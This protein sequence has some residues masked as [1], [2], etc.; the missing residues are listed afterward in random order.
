M[1]L[2]NVGDIL[3]RHGL[4]VLMIDFDLEAPGLE[5]YFQVDQRKIRA[6]LGLFDLILHYKAAMA[7]PATGEERDQQFRQLQERFISQIYPR[8]NGGGQLD[9]MTAG[10]RG[11]DEQ[12]AQY[13]LNLRQFDWQDFFFN[14]GGELFFD[15]LRRALD[16]R[17][18]DVVLVDSRTGVTEMGGICAYQLADLIVMLCGANQQNLDGTYDIVRNFSS[19]RVKMLRRNRELPM[20][21]VPAR[22]ELQ[23]GALVADYR[24]R[25]EALFGNFVPP[26]LAKSG[27]KFWDLLIPYEPQ[28][29]FQERVLATGN[30]RERRSAMRAALQNLVDAIG[31]L[32]EADDPLRTFVSKQTKAA[33]AA[34]PEYDLTSR[35]A[36]FD[37]FLSHSQS[38]APAVR[39]IAGA[40]RR[41]KLRIFLDTSN[42]AMGEA[43][44]RALARALEQSRA[45]AVFV[46]PSTDYPW[47][48]E[49]VRAEIEASIARGLKLVPVLL[50]G[51]SLPRTSDM[52]TYLL[53]LQWCVFERL[54][55]ADAVERLSNA[56]TGAGP[57][58]RAGTTIAEAPPYKGLQAF[59]EPDA[60]FFFGREELVEEMIGALHRGSFL[61][62]IGASSIGKTSV[63][64][65]GLIPALRSGAIP[66]SQDWQF[67]FVTPR[68]D[69]FRE[70]VRAFSP[71]VGF[72]SRSAELFQDADD[73]V[74]GLRS[75]WNGK[76]QLLVIDQFE[77]IFVLAQPDASAKFE[78]AITKIALTMGDEI[79]IVII[80]RSDFVD[81]VL[82]LP[83]LADLVRNNLLVVGPLRRD[84][85]RSAI[86]APA[87]KAGLALEP[88]LTDLLLNDLA[89]AP[90]ALPLLQYVLYRLWQKRQSG[91]LT[92]EAYREM[93]GVLHAL[94]HEAE[95]F[96]S[97]HSNSEPALQ[98][99][100]TLK[101]AAIRDDG[102]P[103]RRRAARSEFTT[104][105][106][107]LVSAL[108]DR[109]LLVTGTSATGEPYVEVAHEAIFR[110]WDRLRDW[111][112]AER[113]F[114]MWRNR[115]EN[116]RHVWQ[117]APPRSRDEA[118]LMGFAL[119]QAQ[120]YL[121][122]R[123]KDFSPE[124]RQFVISSIAA[125]RRRRLYIQALFS[126]LASAMLFGVLGWLNQN[127][128]R[129]QIQ[130]YTITRPY[131]RSQILPYVLSEASEQ[132]LKPGDSFRECAAA[133]P[134]MVVVPEGSFV[135]GSSAD[136]AG[137]RGENPKHRV[138]ITRLF[139]IS[140]Y[141]L[142]FEDWDACVHVGVCA[143]QI[144]D[145]GF[146][147]GRR[148][149][150]NVSWEGANRYVAWLSSTTG[151]HYRLLSE[152][153][154]EY[155]ARA[156]T[157][158]LFPWGDDV[159]KANANCN[160][161]GS[162]WDNRQTAPAGSFRPNGFG[163]YN[164]VGNVWEWV[165]DCWHPSY[166]GAPTDGSAW[167]SGGDCGARAGRG[168]S[169]ISPPHDVRSASRNY[170]SLEFTSANLGFRI[171]RSLAR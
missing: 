73:L 119:T 55:D 130:F 29:A 37:A 71:T 41:R 124:D 154:Y 30:P 140:K 143:S 70:L 88:A 155:A 126:A 114:L 90:G 158:T 97:Q 106:W 50:P 68:D 13:A 82:Q 27:M 127:Y 100:F 59:D 56:L 63:L 110:F 156:G 77:E 7:V 142:T 35:S 4:R 79:S 75:N 133:C 49:Y 84:Q 83:S 47:R 81:R 104:D 28:Q 91:Y 44:K 128:L 102:M 120:H 96:L 92:A 57:V 11:D 34:E 48:Q 52:P 161:C 51:A 125:N 101:L 99:I 150:I 107:D 139:A 20:I 6:N 39:E 170:F 163:L 112:A 141:E 80:V 113:E 66:G 136:Q 61:A 116:A 138:T 147:R 164:M 166:D 122:E 18:Y 108:I 137:S 43:W 32:A 14:W 169:W 168:G 153:E 65:A 78:H 72:K 26:A 12:L 121:G 60:P 98:R 2:A 86:E 109:R 40:L 103:A 162:E 9:L 171:G 58:R 15:W 134:E 21:V 38:D 145:S 151:K 167:I 146:G 10:Q 93:G 115:L 3:A 135:M 54:D 105:E 22:I 85:L 159:G 152:A 132:A 42:I 33:I 62:V 16:R 149:V 5:Q 94:A 148:P 36:G 160:G 157:S 95:E 67:V 87:Y 89:D 123:G 1:A 24:N 31:A 129:Q 76:R 25:F 111:I 45:C 46:G 69:P 19:P 165:E 64:R 23:D 8:R 118:L 144:G 131:I 117:V 17:L 53:N 74:K